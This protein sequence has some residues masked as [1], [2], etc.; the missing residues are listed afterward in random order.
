[1]RI[2]IEDVFKASREEVEVAIVLLLSLLKAKD[3]EFAK[4]EKLAERD[5]IARLT[6]RKTIEGAVREASERVAKE[7][8][9]E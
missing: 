4:Q 7:P 9:D 2:E 8:N 5:R 3:A 1:M 6:E